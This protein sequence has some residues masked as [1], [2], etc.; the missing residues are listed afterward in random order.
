MKELERKIDARTALLAYQS[1]LDHGTRDGE[2]YQLGELRAQ[3]DFDG[4]TTILSDGTV[5]VRI[6]FHSRVDID[7]P[8]A[9]ALERFVQRLEAAAQR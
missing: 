8:D 6:L 7:A 4:Y 5:T 1:V 2:S 9:R 3:S